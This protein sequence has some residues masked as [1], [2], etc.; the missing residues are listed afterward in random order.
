M[1]RVCWQDAPVFSV[2]LP[3]LTHGSLHTVLHGTDQAAD[4]C[5]IPCTSCLVDPCIYVPTQEDISWALKLCLATDIAQGVQYL[6]NTL[7]HSVY[8]YP[9]M[10]K[11]DFYIWLAIHAQADVLYMGIYVCTSRWSIYG[12]VSMHEQVFYIWVSIYARA[13]VLYMGN[14]KRTMLHVHDTISELLPYPH[15]GS[16]TV[17][18]MI[19]SNNERQCNL[20]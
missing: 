6:H 9:S 13:G 12:H 4:R 3:L 5:H 1:Y 11:Q 19:L 14:Y 7:R 20:L 18:S 17:M 16:Y 2:V 15:T 8:G 10:H